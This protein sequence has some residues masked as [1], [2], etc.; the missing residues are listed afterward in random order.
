MS[1]RSIV[2]G[3]TLHLSVCFEISQR[4]AL[5]SKKTP[6]NTNQNKAKQNKTS[7]LL[8]GIDF[9]KRLSISLIDLKMADLNKRYFHSKVLCFS[10]ALSAVGIRNQC[11]CFFLDFKRTYPEFFYIAFLGSFLQGQSLLNF[12]PRILKPIVKIKRPFEMKEN[13]KNSCIRCC[14]I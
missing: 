2:L 6:Q 11:H 12:P 3:F 1:L 14:G 8:Y 5:S 9:P 4:S 10:K 7:A 13:G